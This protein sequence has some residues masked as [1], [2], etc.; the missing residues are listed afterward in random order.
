MS[1]WLCL[2]SDRKDF[3]LLYDTNYEEVGSAPLTPTSGG[4]LVQERMFGSGSSEGV[5]KLMEE[6]EEET[7]QTNQQK[8][9]AA[10]EERKKTIG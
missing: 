1:L 7:Q 8:T 2:D 10:G 9:M 6:K 3:C 4:A 5:R